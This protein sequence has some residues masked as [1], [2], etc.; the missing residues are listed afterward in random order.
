M[1]DVG[2]LARMLVPILMKTQLIYRLSPYLPEQGSWFYCWVY[3]L[4][5][6]GT[7][8]TRRRVELTTERTLLSDD[9]IR[10]TL[11]L[12][13]HDPF[14]H[15]AIIYLYCRWKFE[16]PNTNFYLI[17][18][19]P[20]FY[21]LNVERSWCRMRWRTVDFV[22]ANPNPT[23]LT[24]FTPTHKKYHVRNGSFLVLCLKCC[25]ANYIQYR[26]EN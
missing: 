16:I 11:L 2:S 26:C 6:I 9:W 10:S 17:L 24:A 15:P 1:Q 8:D 20:I 25:M 14:I 3:S 7:G 4:L 21:Y 19:I 23:K 22:M 5:I 12:S 13:P 18:F